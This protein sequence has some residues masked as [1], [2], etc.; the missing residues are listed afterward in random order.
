MSARSTT[1][2]LA[3]ALILVL[4]AT[5]FAFDGNRK[6]FVL[7]GGFGAG[8]LS[9][10]LSESEHGL[11]FRPRDRQNSITGATDIRVGYGFS[12]ALVL[13]YV[14]KAHWFNVIFVKQRGEE[15]IEKKYLAAAVVGGVGM[16]YYLN[17]ESSPLYLTI[18]LPVAGWLAPLLEHSEE[19]PTLRAIGPGVAAGVGYEFAAHSSVEAQITWGRPRDTESDITFNTFGVMIT[20]NRLVY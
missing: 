5:S 3:L 9:V 10:K 15:K 17:P 18:A 14:S 16:S 6:G 4:T 11:T 19:V 20:V 8:Y 7:G 13:Y 2:I 1:A 12:E